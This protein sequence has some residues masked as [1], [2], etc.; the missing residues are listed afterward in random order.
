M[1]QKEWQVFVVDK[2]NV[3]ICHLILIGMS[4]AGKEALNG[5][6]V[7]VYCTQKAGEFF[8]QIQPWRQLSDNGNILLKCFANPLRE[9]ILGN[10]AVVPVLVPH[11]NELSDTLAFRFRT[12]PSPGAMDGREGTFYC[13]DTDGSASPS[14]FLTSWMPYLPWSYDAA[15]F[16]FRPIS[17]EDSITWAT[18]NDWSVPIEVLS[19]TR[20]WVLCL[21]QVEY[22]FP[23]YFGI[24]QAWRS[25]ICAWDLCRL[26]KAFWFAFKDAQHSIYVQMDWMA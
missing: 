7:L 26:Q 4:I 11:R 3:S 5:S 20:Q 13:P 24:L 19:T 21:Q 14:K 17:N 16:I 10:F 6:K 2:A 8:R 9:E 1:L 23:P 18:Q 15:N 22:I 12:Y 25:S